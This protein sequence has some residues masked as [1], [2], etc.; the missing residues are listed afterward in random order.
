MIKA[1][2]FD[3]DGTLANTLPDLLTSINEMRAHFGHPPITEEMLLRAVNYSTSEYVRRA[4]PEDFDAARFDEATEAYFAAYAKHYL[5]KTVPYAGLVEMLTRL[6]SEG[7]KLAVMTNKDNDFANRL[8]AKLF[9][10][11][12][13]AVWGTVDGIPVKPDPTRAFMI[14][15][16]FSLSPEDIAF[17]GDS[18]VD[19]L[20]ANNAGMVPVAVSWG[21]R[22]K[23]ILQQNG[24]KFIVDDA[25]ALYATLS[26]L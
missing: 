24:A 18:D 26:L 5:E 8:V 12:F 15:R 23:D 10:S 2:V 1:A 17:I 6:R 4:L 14:A 9:P 16:D 3:F 13:D 25:D 21:Y 19:M 11:I 22:E 20:T 7:V